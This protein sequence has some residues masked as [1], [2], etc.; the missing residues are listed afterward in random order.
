[1]RKSRPEVMSEPHGTLCNS[2]IS[3]GWTR[4]GNCRKRIA[5]RQLVVQKFIKPVGETS[6]CTTKAP[7]HGTV[8]YR[9]LM[10]AVRTSDR[11]MIPPAYGE[12]VPQTMLRQ[13]E[14]VC[15]VRQREGVCNDGN[16]LSPVL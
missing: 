12:Q 6:P 8:S 4:P 2:S 10:S 11:P 16:Q 13:R 7:M 14:G 3:G 1:M 15:N 5:A 9:Q